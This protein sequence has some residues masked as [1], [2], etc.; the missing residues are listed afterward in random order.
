M[1]YEGA[2]TVYFSRLQ[3]RLFCKQTRGRGQ[4]SGATNYLTSGQDKAQIE[5]EKCFNGFLKM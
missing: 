1:L 3:P 5:E 2:C 4:E